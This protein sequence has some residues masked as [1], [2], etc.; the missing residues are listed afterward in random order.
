MRSFPSA[1]FP[2]ILI[3]LSVPKG[4]ERSGRRRHG[5]GRSIT[6]LRG[7]KDLELGPYLGVI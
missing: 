1:L 4:E 5:K 3:V 2:S 6:Y 7:L